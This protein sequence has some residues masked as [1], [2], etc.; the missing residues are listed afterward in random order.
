M[1]IVN[2]LFA[3]LSYV[4]TGFNIAI[5]VAGVVG[6]VM[7]LLTRSDAFDA[8]DRQSKFVWVGILAAASLVQLIPV[9]LLSFIGVVAIGVYWFDVYPQLKRLIN[10]DYGW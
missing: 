1:E 7:V 4:V 10:G 3:V 8:G 5:L 6:I 9:M 2:Q